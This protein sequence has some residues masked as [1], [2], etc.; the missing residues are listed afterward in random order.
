MN[1]NT[2]EEWRSCG[3]DY[4]VSNFGE[5]CSWKSGERK[6]LSTYAAGAYAMVN[7]Y[8]SSGKRR[9]YVH[10][11]VLEAF[12]GPCPEGME[13][14]HNDG[15]PKNNHLQNLRWDTRKGNIGDRFTHGTIKFGEGCPSS[16]LKPHHVRQIRYLV[17]ICGWKQNHTA[18]LYGVT[19]GAVNHICLGNRWGHLS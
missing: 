17:G 4:E 5:V 8:E 1:N 10:R 15:N 11:L 18:R 6:I 19:K 12:V 13:C 3:E 14:C 7:L 2:K 9:A 16:K